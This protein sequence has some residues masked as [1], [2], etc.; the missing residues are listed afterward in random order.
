MRP[1]LLLLTLTALAA[2]GPSPITL[3]DG[4]PPACP[5]T[6]PGSGPCMPIGLRCVYVQP[7]ASCPTRPWLCEPA[8]GG[9]QGAWQVAL[10]D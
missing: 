1:T 9:S 6:E 5:A 8:D 3:Q 7:G 4:S 2:C 10:C